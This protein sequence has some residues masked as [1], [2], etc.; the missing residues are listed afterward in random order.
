MDQRTGY[1]DGTAR[2][3]RGIIP[4]CLECHA[5]CFDSKFPSAASNVY[6]TANFV[7]GISCE[8]CHGPGRAHVQAQEHG[9]AAKAMQAAGM[10]IV[11]PA[12][13]S[14]RRRAEICRQCHGGHGEPEA[15]PA[16]SYIPGQPVLG[17]MRSRSL[18]LFAPS[19]RQ[20]PCKSW[21][22]PRQN[23]RAAD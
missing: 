1:V 6:N 12:K 23:F 18:V 13:L 16:F 22:P 4:R 14:S 7:L 5:A 21:K 19:L 3:D 20:N 15:L 2:F 9:T 10:S 17:R 8:R 11:N